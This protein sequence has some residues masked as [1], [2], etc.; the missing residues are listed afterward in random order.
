MTNPQT[1]TLATLLHSANDGAAYETLAPAIEELFSDFSDERKADL[2][3]LLAEAVTKGMLFT[4]LTAAINRCL[5][6]N[7]ARFMGSFRA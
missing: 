6:K 4:A 7:E 5:N 3:A 2:Y 1:H